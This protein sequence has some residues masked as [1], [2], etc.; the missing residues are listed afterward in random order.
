[1][2]LLLLFAIYAASN[3]VYAGG[4]LIASYYLPPQIEALGGFFRATG[5]FI[6]PVAYALTGLSVAAVFRWV[7]PSVAFAIAAAAVWLQ[8][9]EAQPIQNYFKT[10]T[11][12]ADAES[13]DLE[14]FGRL[15]HEHERVWQYPSYSCGGLA[16]PTRQWGGLDTNR[17]LQLQLLAARAGVPTNSVYM[18]RMLKHCDRE[19]QWADAPRFEDGV[20]YFLSWKTTLE[21][22][23][24]ARLVASGPCTGL[25]WG[26]VCSNTFRTPPRMD[27]AP[28]AP[29]PAAA[30]GK[31]PV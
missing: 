4:T 23:A 21:T 29:A 30:R 25:S 19:S 22:P 16:G 8:L 11:G 26:I 28:P 3:R 20:L 31:P 24:I 18:S 10:V 27:Q 2:S 15:I 12:R 14:Y 7:R 13:L 6:W 9:Q 17:E 1:V 5:R